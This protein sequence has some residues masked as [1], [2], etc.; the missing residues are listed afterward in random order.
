MAPFKEE[1]SER[2]ASKGVRGQGPTHA[3][4]DGRELSENRSFLSAEVRQKSYRNGTSG[5]FVGAQISG[6]RSLASVDIGTYVFRSRAGG[7]NVAERRCRF[8]FNSNVFC[9]T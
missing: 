6:L 8:L 9:R 1:S 5:N 3:V 2:A 4:T 7:G